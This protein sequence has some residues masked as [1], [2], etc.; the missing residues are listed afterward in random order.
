MKAQA[1]KKKILVTDFDPVKMMREIREKLTKEIM[2]MSH[3][4][5]KAYIKKLISKG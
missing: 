5:E 3:E 2:D 4:Q 1:N